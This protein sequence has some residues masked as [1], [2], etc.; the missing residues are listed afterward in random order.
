VAGFF[1]RLRERRA[2]RRSA[3]EER[4]KRRASDPRDH[5]L[6]AR[7]DSQAKTWEKHGP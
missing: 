7:K 6:Q 2:Q 5:V 1:N 4:G 3:R